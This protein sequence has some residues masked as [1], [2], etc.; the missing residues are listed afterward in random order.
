MSYAVENERPSFMQALDAVRQ[1]VGQIE[2]AKPLAELYTFP[3]SP[4]ETRSINLHTPIQEL[5]QTEP[6]AVSPTQ[7]SEQPP[8][9]Q[10]SSEARK[11]L[12]EE[13]IQTARGAYLLLKAEGQ[14]NADGSLE[15]I[16]KQLRL[17]PKGDVLLIA[18]AT[19]PREILRLEGKTIVL[20][21]PR[22][23]DQPQLQRLRQVFA[24]AQRQQRQ[25]NQQQQ[26]GPRL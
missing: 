13:A 1:I 16:G 20:F 23:E 12:E 7:Q 8:I 11:R 22:P 14:E 17:S 6:V 4:A 26:R 21:N 24:V 10:L 25:Q 3:N 9:I 5:S 18:S 2:L 19:E 15:L